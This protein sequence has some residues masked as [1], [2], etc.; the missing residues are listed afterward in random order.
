METF[1]TDTS[2]ATDVCLTRALVRLGHADSRNDSALA[3]SVGSPAASAVSVDVRS[4]AASVR[5]FACDAASLSASQVRGPAPRMPV[6]EPADASDSEA[7][8]VLQRRVGRLRSRTSSLA[9]SDDSDASSEAGSTLSRRVARLRRP[10]SFLPS[11]H[12]ESLDTLTTGSSD[13]TSKAGSVLSRRVA[14]LRKSSLVVSDVSVIDKSET[15][16]RAPSEAGSV[17][18]RRVA[19]LGQR[20]SLTRSD[21]DVIVDTS[22]SGRSD[23]APSDAR[24]SLTRRVARLRLKPSLVSSD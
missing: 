22:A 7:G 5:L 6:W 10:P 2:G 24:L 20:L 16:D 15:S 17:L 14:R 4:I 21:D 18:S 12:N 3:V 9:L 11:E 23:E 13:E 1:L 19:R 8:S